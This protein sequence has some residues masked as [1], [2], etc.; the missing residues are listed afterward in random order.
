M[1]RKSITAALMGDQ[2]MEAIVDK[3]YIKHIVSTQMFCTISKVILDMRTA[4]VIEVYKDNKLLQ[5]FAISPTLADKLE[6]VKATLGKNE[7]T[8]KFLTNNK[9]VQVPENSYKAPESN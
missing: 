2:S 9:K 6:E 4:I 8:V 1:N 3:N 5:A 7:L